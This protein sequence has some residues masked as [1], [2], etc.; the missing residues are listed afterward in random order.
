[1]I[2][3]TILTGLFVLILLSTLGEH[4]TDDEPCTL[5]KIEDLM[6]A[7]WGLMETIYFGI[8]DLF[9]SILRGK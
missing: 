4:L 2:I 6:D 5:M 1:M 3:Y 9:K 8:G 7:I